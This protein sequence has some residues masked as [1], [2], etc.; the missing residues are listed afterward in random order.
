MQG[1]FIN[2]SRPKSK[3]AVKEAVASGQR[4]RVEATSFFGNEYDG[5]LF[6]DDGPAV[7]TYRFVG[8]DPYTRRNF[9]GTITVKDDGTVLVK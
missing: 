7:G 8:P 3:K 6:T 2:G 5:L 1:I 4:V 9:Y